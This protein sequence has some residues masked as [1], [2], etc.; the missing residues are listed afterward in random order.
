MR[1]KLNDVKAPVA[2]AFIAVAMVVGAVVGLAV[3]RFTDGDGGEGQAVV[4]R[5]D[6]PSGA[7]GATPA[8]PKP[9]AVPA[10][11]PESAPPAAAAGIAADEAGRVAVA[12]VGGGVVDHVERED[13]HG[14]AWEVD[15]ATSVGEY[16]VYIDATGQA[17]RVLGPFA[18]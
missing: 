1:R 5:A 15:I 9:S 12:R 3:A 4:D 18:D 2:A 14:A 16:E 6:A 7:A 11:A 13:D 10:P 17:V 8:T